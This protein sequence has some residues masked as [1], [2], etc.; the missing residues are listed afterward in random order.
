MQFFYDHK[1]FTSDI[2]PQNPELW[3]FSK[4]G[5][6]VLRER[7]PW[8]ETVGGDA[9]DEGNVERGEADEVGHAQREVWMEKWWGEE[10]RKDEEKEG[11]EIG[12][13]LYFVFL[14]DYVDSLDAIGE[15]V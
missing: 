14:I 2:E 8:R 7:M 6:R 4:H 12:G 15:R 3:E 1:L 11:R 10:R 13:R 9:C 5:T